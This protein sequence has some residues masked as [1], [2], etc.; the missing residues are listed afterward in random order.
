MEILLEVNF[1][2]INFYFSTAEHN[3]APFCLI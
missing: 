1:C 3:P 2:F